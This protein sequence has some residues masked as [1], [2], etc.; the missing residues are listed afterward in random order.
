MANIKINVN[1]PEEQKQPVAPTPPIPEPTPPVPE[2]PI[3][4]PPIPE[5]TQTFTQPEPQFDRTSLLKQEEPEE[6]QEEDTGKKRKKKKKKDNTP[7]TTEEAYQAFKLR[8]RIIFIAIIVTMVACV[9]FGVYNIFFKHYLTPQ[10]AAVYTNSYNGQS[11]TQKW[12]SGVQGFLQR[13]LPDLLAESFASGATANEFSVDNI[14]VERNIPLGDDMI[15]TYFSADFTSNQTTQRVYCSIPISTKGN[16]LRV[17]GELSISTRRAFSD[18]GIDPVENEFLDFDDRQENQNE[19][20]AFQSVLENFLTLGYNSKQDVSNIYTGDAKLNFDGATFVDV[21]YCKVYDQA[22][23]L[24]YNAR[25]SY[26]L[27][28][29]NGGV[30]VTT[31]YMKISKNAGTYTIEAIM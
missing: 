5:P 4:A 20:K 29:D 31:N 26:R 7:K 23:E 10:E 13:N 19:G 24:G 8:K 16:K 11:V 22:N 14:S 3:Q 18:N 2:P 25:V 1:K 30:F 27:Q 21:V 6:E 15:L 9:G 28:L 12:D 17:A